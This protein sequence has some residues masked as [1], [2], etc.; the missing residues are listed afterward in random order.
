MNLKQIAQIK[1]NWTG[2]ALFL[3]LLVGISV[4]GQILA[5][6]DQRNKT[7]EILSRGNHLV[8]LM[9]LHSINDFESDKRDFFLRALTEYAINQGLVYCFVNDQ[10]GRALVS[11][12]PE[13]LAAKIPNDVQMRALS[14]NGL[15]KQ[16]FEPEGFEYEIFEFSKPVFENGEK[17]GTV[18]VGLKRPD[19]SLFS[20]E[21]ISLLATFVFF[22]IS[23][24]IILFYGFKR[25]LRPLELLKKNISGTKTDAT[26]IAENS[27]RDLKITP[28]VED[29]QNSM[30]QFKE[31]LE[32]VETKNLELTSRLGV[33]S[34]E[35]NQII[36]II[37]S[38]NF[39]IIIT[40]LQDNVGYVN[41]YFL[42]LLNKARETVVDRPLNEVLNHDEIIAFISKTETLGQTRLSHLDTNFPECAPGEIFKISLSHLLDGEKT[43]IGKMIMCNNI[44]T[45][46]TAEN[47]IQQ[48]LAHLAHEL[49]TPLTTI[50]SYSEMLMDGEVEDSET[51][52]EF[53]NT[54]NEETDRL[55]RLIKDLL[56]MSKMETGSLTLNKDLVKSDWLFEDCITAV[57]GTARKKSISIKR[58]LPDHF[59]SLIG[60]KDQLKASI[61]NILGNSVKYTPEGGRIE[62]GLRE[63]D[64]MVVFEIIDTGYGMSDE[65]L[66]HIFDK[67]YR[68]DNPQ[69][70]EQQGAGLG[71]AIASEIVQL[72][73][74]EI[75]VQ[76]ELGKG[77]HFTIK[78]PQEDF[79]LGK[80]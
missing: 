56:N 64:K 67:F 41:D 42:N 24:V 12:A 51:Q 17:T 27:L 70:A 18:R 66:T 36:N 16:T 14:A 73:D 25:A 49:M 38:V 75:D 20:M 60:D 4:F 44:T 61:I 74:G 62:F 40:D 76:S 21:K 68:S 57:E 28:L 48:I 59:P 9:A 26:A 15:E 19:P 1:D 7:Q 8:S 43:P 6:R 46:K 39:G 23:A 47:A 32:R 79:Y 22:F 33:M 45:E 10:S 77:T 35:K 34:F 31:R 30:T 5:R 29:L 54:I 63:Q 71:L 69:I 53:Y 65:E 13:N 55:T 80:Q 58:N 78:I 52:K 2:I 50:K 37:N 72:H 11:L 3:F